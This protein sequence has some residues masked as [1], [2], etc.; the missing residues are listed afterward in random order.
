[1]RK[2][3]KKG[4]QHR[5]RLS[6][7]ERRSVGPNKETPTGHNRSK[8]AAEWEAEA[9]DL[10]RRQQSRREQYRHKASIAKMASIA[11]VPESKN[12]Y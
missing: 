9:G 5:H 11:E 3:E 1:M 4:D 2:K 7:I 8:I 6:Q 10:L 12:Q